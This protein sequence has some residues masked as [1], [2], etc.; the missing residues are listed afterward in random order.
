VCDGV[1]GQC[2]SSSSSSAM[3]PRRIAI[4]MTRQQSASATLLICI[5]LFIIAQLAHAA[6][7]I[8][9]QQHVEPPQ[10]SPSPINPAEP[11][12]PSSKR[13]AVS[14]ID[15]MLQEAM[16]QTIRD[17]ILAGEQAHAEFCVCPRAVHGEAMCKVMD[18][19]CR[20][21]FCNPICL[22]S[23]WQVE[24]EV[25]CAAAPEWKACPEFARQVLEVQPAIAAQFQAHI[26]LQTH[27]CP[28]TH[29]DQVANWVEAA[30]HGPLW[31]EH[32][33]PIPACLRDYHA[34]HPRIGQSTCDACSRIVR[35][36][37][38]RGT[39]QMGFVPGF[40]SR[41][42]SALQERCEYVADYI[43]T[44]A[45]SLL[46]ELQRSVCSCLGCCDTAARDGTG[47]L[48]CFFPNK[49]KAWLADLV[50]SVTKD[51]TEKI[52]K[53]KVARQQQKKQTHRNKQGKGTLNP[54]PPP[55]P[56]FSLK[57]EL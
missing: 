32:V 33:L 9:S 29:T 54:T 31:P 46:L 13:P 40:E 20:A 3:I 5:L 49:G 55:Q 2:H 30:S 24:L 28:T 4:N 44:H 21:S 52:Q 38:R 43:S 42:M 12:S 7:V 27:L 11:S 23:A 47:G 35:A 22:S 45:H 48:E 15:D 1:I 37:I 10:S 14:R 6:D 41:E 19:S 17:G 34:L 50:Q 57:T 36:S 18:D 26:C 39:C 16:E 8:Q 25:D 51:V 53:E 56:A